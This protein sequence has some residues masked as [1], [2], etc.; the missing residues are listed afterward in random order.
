[1]AHPQAVQAVVALRIGH[2]FLDQL[3]R[4]LAL[5]EN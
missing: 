1:M 4:V 5:V 2:R 3:Q